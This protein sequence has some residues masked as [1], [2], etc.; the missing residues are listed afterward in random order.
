MCIGP[1]AK[2][3]VRLIF[4]L[5][6]QWLKDQGVVERLIDFI[7]PTVDPE[8]SDACI[9]ESTDSLCRDGADAQYMQYLNKSHEIQPRTRFKLKEVLSIYLRVLLQPAK[10]ISFPKIIMEESQ[11]QKCAVAKS[12]IFFSS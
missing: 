12:A 4:H 10:L 2:A 8:V 7:R 1:S 11:I 6:L 3:W 5:P 9:R